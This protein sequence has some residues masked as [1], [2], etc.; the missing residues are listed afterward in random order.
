M[1]WDK[2]VH[3]LFS[4][5]ELGKRCR[6]EI[7]EQHWTCT[8]PA[9]LQ[10]KLCEAADGR[11]H[12]E[13]LLFRFENAIWICKIRNYVSF[14]AWQWSQTASSIITATFAMDEDSSKTSKSGRIRKRP[15]KFE[16]FETQGQFL[17][18]LQGLIICYTK[19]PIFKGIF[20]LSFW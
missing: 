13:L 16:D 20:V 6:V 4:A 7:C 9:L 14:L 10:C 8:G 19:T 17:A 15:I 18:Y 11:I 5:L 12:F 2:S 1:S 3:V